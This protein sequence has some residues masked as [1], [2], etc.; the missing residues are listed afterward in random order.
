MIKFEGYTLMTINEIP[1]DENIEL[2]MGLKLLIFPEYIMAFV[3]QPSYCLSKIF[4][5]EA[6]A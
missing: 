2:T 3:S 1:P 6:A 5:E 4:E